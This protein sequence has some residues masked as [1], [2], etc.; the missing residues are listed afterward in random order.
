M[1]RRSFAFA[2]SLALLLTTV[3]PSAGVSGSAEANLLAAAIGGTSHDWILVTEAFGVDPSSGLDVRVGKY[4]NE[5]LDRAA[6]VVT[7]I[8][9]GTARLDDLEARRAAAQAALPPFERKADVAL[10]NV[11]ADIE[12]GLDVRQTVP[13]GIFVSA[14]PRPAVD[15]VFANHPEI[16]RDGDI[17][18]P[19]SVDAKDAIEQE[20]HAARAAVYLAAEDVVTRQLEAVGA[21]IVYRSTGAPLLFATIPANLVRAVASLPKRQVG[22]QRPDIRRRQH[23]R[24]PHGDFQ[25]L[26]LLHEVVHSQ[27]RAIRPGRRC[28]E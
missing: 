15:A 24:L 11:V 1:G 13:V 16:A 20:L 19:T 28:V 8:A 18:R 5:Q 21:T 17:P 26:Y 6:G 10:Q 7:E 27:L 4:Y 22:Q 3:V 25:R 12:K 14:D 2:L 9:T 23:R